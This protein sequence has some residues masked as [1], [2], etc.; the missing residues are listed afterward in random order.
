MHDPTPAS[1]RAD[2]GKARMVSNADPGAGPRVCYGGWVRVPDSSV[3][4]S[5]ALLVQFVELSRAGKRRYRSGTSAARL[6]PGACVG[7]VVCSEEQ[8][9]ALGM[10]A[11]DPE[12][13]G[14]DV[15]PG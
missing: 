2:Q 15:L 9:R 3:H 6:R 7:L 14:S 13:E 1:P 4:G 11:C 10:D 8:A 5:A 12:P